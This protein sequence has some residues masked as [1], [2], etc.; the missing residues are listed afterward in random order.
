M[1][2]CKNTVAIDSSM[3]TVTHYSG[4]AVCTVSYGRNYNDRLFVD[5]STV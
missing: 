5:Y 3:I 1:V 4:I 2:D